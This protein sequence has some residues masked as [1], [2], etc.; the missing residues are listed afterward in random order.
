MLHT[1]N[2]KEDAEVFSNMKQLKSGDKPP[3]GGGEQK[4]LVNVEDA[5]CILMMVILTKELNY[6]P[7]RG[8]VFYQ[9]SS[10][11]FL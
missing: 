4:T 2:I 5:S 9:T 3:D 11:K 10:H 8:I 6:L 1:K 7:Y